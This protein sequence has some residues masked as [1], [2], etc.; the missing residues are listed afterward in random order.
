MFRRRELNMIRLEYVALVYAGEQPLS[1]AAVDLVPEQ[2]AV[3]C[4]LLDGILA[5]S[6]NDHTVL[7]I[8][9]EQARSAKCG[10][11]CRYML[12]EAYVTGSLD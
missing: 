1:F 7:G 12:L 2:M 4:A 11:H 9:A 8:I 5:L 3:E 10:R 6:T